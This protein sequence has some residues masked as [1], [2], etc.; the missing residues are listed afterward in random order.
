MHLA[1]ETFFISGDASNKIDIDLKVRLV[2]RGKKHWGA[3]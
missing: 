2:I 3:I 1:A